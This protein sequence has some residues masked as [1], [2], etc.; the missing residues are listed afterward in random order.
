MGNY[1]IAV[2]T[3]CKDEI[4]N[5]DQWMTSMFEADYICVLDTGSKDG[6]YE[7]LL[8]WQK[9]F[10][11]KVIISQKTYSPWRFD[12]PRNDSLALIPKDADIDISTDLDERLVFG[13]SDLFKKA[14]DKSISKKQLAYK[15]A[16]S[17]NQDG[18]PARV[19]WYNKCHDNSGKWKWYYPV[20][21]TLVYDD[22]PKAI[23]PNDK[24]SD[25]ILLHHFPANKT[26]RSNYLPLLELRAKENPN[27]YYGLVYLAHEYYYQGLYQKSIDFIEQVAFPKISSQD[28]YCCKTDL[29]LFK[30]KA[31]LALNQ[32]QK[33]IISFKQGIVE[34]PE[35]RDNYLCLAEAYLMTREYNKAIDAVHEALLH[36]RR[37]Y[38]WLEWDKSWTT[39]PADILSNAYYYLG[40]KNTALDYAE[41]AYQK[42]KKDERLYHNYCLIL[43]ELKGEGQG[44]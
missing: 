31:Y 25:D 32:T 28:L 1:K 4:Q 29:Y 22:N 13:W 24:V 14:W 23:I 5:V 18:T 20:H 30:G 34:T 41:M 44:K 8:S 7:K 15:Y 19:F 17:H 16:W 21:E 43:Q 3:I 33:A 27:D 38:S 40:A 37:L 39:L 2:Y 36:S 11:Q 10:P 35:F 42:D 12:T 26:S 9:K 6:T